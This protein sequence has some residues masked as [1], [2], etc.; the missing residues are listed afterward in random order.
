MLKYSF[1]S[2]SI[3]GHPFITR[4]KTKVPSLQITF[5]F[6]CIEG[7]PFITRFKTEDFADPDDYDD[8]MY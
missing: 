5:M 2:F 8:Y 4:F 6:L 7:H 1:I 3:E